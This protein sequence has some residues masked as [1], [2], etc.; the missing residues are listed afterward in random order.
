MALPGRP[1]AQRPL[2]LIAGL[3]HLLAPLLFFTDRTQNPYL[4]QICLI[5]A[6]VFMAFLALAFSL[7]R[8]KQIVWQPTV[9][10]L[11][12]LG[13]G[14]ASALTWAIAVYRGGVLAPSLYHEGLR[15]AV[16]LWANGLGVFF[17]S[18][19]TALDVR[20]SKLQNLMMGVGGVAALY[21]LIQYAGFDPLWP[22][23]V[24]PFTGRPISTFGNPN[25]LSTGL[26]LLIPL[27]LWKMMTA[28]RRG[29]V[30]IAGGLAL[31]YS[32]ALLSTMTRSSYLGGLIS[33][34]LFAW[35]SRDLIRT[36]PRRWGAWLL[37][38]GALLVFWPS[39]RLASNAPTPAARVLEL[40]NGVV[41]QKIYASWHQ[42]L[43]IWSCAL[44]MWRSRPWGGT[45]WGLFEVFF[46]FFQ[47]RYLSD[48]LFRGFRTH[49]NNA[50]QLI[51]EWGS[52]TGLLGVGALLWLGVTAFALHWSRRAGPTDLR[53]SG[54]ARWA[55]LAGVAV[56]NFFGNVSLFFA[57][58]CF[59]FCWVG[60]Q[61]AVDQT[62]PV[63]GRR[64]PAGVATVLALV[65]AA[66]AGAGLWREWRTWRAAEC[67]L[68]ALRE[69]QSGDMSRAEGSLLEARRW[70][71]WDVHSAYER[72]N[73]YA[74][75]ARWAAMKGLPGEKEENE[76]RA[77]EAY[78][79]AVASN[80]GYDETYFNRAGLWADR[81]DLE[82]A[83]Q[84]YRMSLLI[85]PLNVDAHRAL[86]ALWERRPPSIGAVR[87][88]YERAVFFFPGRAEFWWG[89]TRW[90]EKSG[91]RAGARRAAAEG[92]R[93]DLDSSEGWAALRRLSPDG[94]PGDL[95]PVP[96]LLKRIRR[97]AAA[98]RW[99]S[100]RKAA[101]TLR[102]SVP[103]SPLARLM[104]ADLAS[105]QG[106]WA[107]AVSEYRAFLND[108]PRHRDARLN[109]AGALAS[110]GRRSEARAE[111]ESL[112]ADFP[113]DPAVRDRL[114]S[115]NDT[116]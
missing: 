74:R 98:S 90:C 55:G 45:G 87:D 105:R 73:L 42:R 8:E 49:A 34:I 32:A 59:L 78:G 54:A 29:A 4:V 38:L 68:R 56:D 51:L 9:L 53:W 66:I 91:D 25:F 6:G 88:L 22:H 102:Q 61:W 13:L 110:S 1:G 103:Q 37:L 114:S 67:H 104:V 81:G 69:I 116:P 71:A 30:W 112:R 35:G 77:L 106:D 64:F 60:G 21:G 5:H 101:E 115:L 41:G 50:H 94:L 86:A 44:D 89:L 43:L 46:P 108:E 58:P 52:Q 36:R 75:R 62:R 85:N 80:A 99:D 70:F 97:E 79:E 100:A 63:K 17:L 39:G 15:G 47:G 11:P 7:Y 82:S 18:T 20:G 19:Q 111:L 23:P 93:V 27:A 76:T 57:V 12:V 16:W 28:Q 33:G 92:V 109:L 83:A 26:V 2:L 95:A 96:D 65:M 3:L 84:D 10:D 24:N 31:L 40:W 72:G 107:V 113:E 48:P 14:I